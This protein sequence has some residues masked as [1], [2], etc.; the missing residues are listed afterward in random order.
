MRCAQADT[1][2][3]RRQRTATA[4]RLLA[5]GMADT[6]VSIASRPAHAHVNV[7]LVKLMPVAQGFAP[8]QA[9]RL[10]SRIDV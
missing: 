7:N 1:D 2:S 5:E 9:H 6:V 4:E 3:G 8:L 10:A